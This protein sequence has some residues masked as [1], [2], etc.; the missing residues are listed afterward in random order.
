MPLPGNGRSILFGLA[1][2]EVDSL[3]LTGP[4][5]GRRIPIAADGVFLDVE[6]GA[7]AFRGATLVTRVDGRI[8]RMPLLR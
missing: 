2:R 4:S 8:R 7:R 3:R 1:D 6:A 5:A